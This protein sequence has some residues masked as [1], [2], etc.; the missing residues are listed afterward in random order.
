MKTVY[1]KL[2]DKQPSMNVD[3]IKD[4]LDRG[5][6]VPESFTHAGRGDQVSN[7]YSGDLFSFT[8]LRQVLSKQREFTIDD[9]KRLILIE[10]TRKNGRPRMSHLARFLRVVENCER[11]EILT[12][13]KQ[14]GNKS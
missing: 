1:P 2:F 6:I 12:K 7:Q 9:A 11:A 10:T 8:V 14:W 5:F 13:I 4:L 3:D